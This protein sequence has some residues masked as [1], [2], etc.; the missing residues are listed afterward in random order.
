MNEI[1]E[2]NHNFSFLISHVG[3]EFFM[4]LEAATLS[5]EALRI[6]D[7]HYK[8]PTRGFYA[9]H[10]LLSSAQKF[11]ELILDFAKRLKILI[12]KN[13]SKEV[14]ITEHQQLLLRD[15]L[16]SGIKND[17]KRMRLLEFSDSDGCLENCT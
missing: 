8:K 12:Q 6:L 2:D 9:R 7:K 5:E 16:V 1:I 10:Q 11:E 15:A 13:E 14:I 4:I 17:I 3:A